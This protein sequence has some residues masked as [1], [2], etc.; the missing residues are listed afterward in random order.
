MEAL[1]LFLPPNPREDSQRRR[2]LDHTV[3]PGRMES[4]LE[5]TPGR[6]RTK[7]A[8]SIYELGEAKLI[9]LG[10]RMLEDNPFLEFRQGSEDLLASRKGRCDWRGV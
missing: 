3:G 10:Q 4:A 2:A 8:E 7:R 9:A 5:G 6:T 1:D